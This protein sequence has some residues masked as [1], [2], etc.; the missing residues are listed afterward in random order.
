MGKVKRI[1]IV[2]GFAVAVLAAFCNYADFMV[3]LLTTYFPRT[4]NLL[5]RNCFSRIGT[6]NI[7]SSINKT[8]TATEKAN[9][10][11]KTGSSFPG[12]NT[13]NRAKNYINATVAGA[14]TESSAKQKEHFD[15]MS[16]SE[17]PLRFGNQYI[18]VILILHV[19]H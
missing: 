15:N 19:V 18:C 1:L 9:N 6:A 3:S 5:P 2:I 12:L 10:N 8:A 4:A 14:G 7:S 13:A 17:N 16:G 11:K